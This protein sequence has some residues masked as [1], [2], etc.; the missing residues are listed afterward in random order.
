[1]EKL[2]KKYADKLAS[3]G[4]AEPGAPLVGGLDADLVW[5]RRAPDRGLLEEV[6]DKLSIN[7]L[8]FSR[9]AEPY[10]SIIDHLA[11]HSQGALVPNDCET[12]TFLHDLPVAREFSSQAIVEALSRRKSV[13]IP[14][15]GVVTFGTV[16]PEQGFVTFSSVCFACFVKFFADYLRDLK[17]GKVNAAQQETFDRVVS[18]LSPPAPAPPRLMRGPFATNEEI[19]EALCQAGRHTVEYGLVDSYFGNISCLMGDTVYISRTGSSLDELEGMID[20]CPMD[21]SS[22]AGLTASSELTAHMEIYSRTQNRA[23]LHGH[24]KFAVIMSLDCDQKD[25]P[26]RGRCHLECPKER[27]VG[28]IPIVAGEVGTGPYGLWRTVPPAIKDRR[29]VIVYGHGVFTAAK[30]DFNKAFG[31]LLFV[32]NMCR[33]EYFARV[34]AR[35]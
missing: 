29:G 21:G 8:V 24:P 23:V 25:C 1:M 14:G 11:K 20:P 10:K 27:F 19:Q 12:R 33:E 17:D 31:S 35:R 34:R 30:D 13:I 32:E 3:A 6:F 28:D 18:L 26:V 15:K 22:C 7:S 2:V 16:S 4:L 9:P 5:N